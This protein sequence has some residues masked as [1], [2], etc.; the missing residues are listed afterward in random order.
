MSVIETVLA[1]EALDSRGN[2][3]VQADVVLRGGARG[4]ALAPSGASTGSREALEMRDGDPSRYGGKGVR[5]AVAGVLREIAPALAGMAADDQQ[6][7][8]GAMAELDGSANKGRLGAN[9]ILAVSL[10]AARAA[11]AG[12]GVPL[13][14]H[15]RDLYGVA[16][17]DLRLPVPMMNILNGGAHADNNVDIQEFMVLPVGAPSFREAV[18]CGVEV[19]HALQAVLREEGLS[20]AVG[21]EGGFAPDL[22]SNAAALERV[23]RAVARAGYDLGRDVVLALDCAA[24]EFCRD[25]RYVL[26]GEG[27]SLDAAGFRAWLADLV[28]RHPIAS[29]EDGM[30]EDDWD[31]WVALTRELGDRVQLV[32]DDLFV[33]NTQYLARGIAA[34]AANAILVKPNQIGTLWET[35]ETLRMAHDRGFATVISHRS[36]ETEDTTIA[37][38]AVGTGAGQIKTGS[39]SRSDRVAKY[40]RLLAIEELLGERA[41]YRGMAELAGAARGAP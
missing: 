37:D 28:A 19:F 8:D 11:A 29:I 26:A 34:G 32:G 24:T 3:T 10:A 17:D 40:N 30:D 25:G 22:P 15:I 41:A 7:V 13:F 27:A 38:I 5:G 16:D 14:R 1:R 6:A 31:G 33:T 39:L 2:P 23:S 36:G 9:A 35:L 21:D 18:R 20:T 12:R 4:S